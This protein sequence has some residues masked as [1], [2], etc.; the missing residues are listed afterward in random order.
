[1]S[2]PITSDEPLQSSSTDGKST[3]ESTTS[4]VSVDGSSSN[5]MHITDNDPTSHSNS[6]GT[7]GYDGSPDR[8]HSYQFSTAT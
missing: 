2:T 6:T 5:P 1:M 3:N 7:E 8:S 4:V